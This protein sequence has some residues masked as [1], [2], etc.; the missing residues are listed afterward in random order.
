MSWETNGV[1]SSKS[2]GKEIEE[3]V[4]DSVRILASKLAGGT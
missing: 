3:D 4:G 1:T 2:V